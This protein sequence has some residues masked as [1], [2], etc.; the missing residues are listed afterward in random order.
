MGECVPQRD[1][2]KR[3]NLPWL[4]KNVVRHKRNAMF[5]IA[6]RS[7]NPTDFAK[8]KEIRNDV[9][10]MLRTAKQSYFDSLTSASSKQVWKM[11]KL[12]NKQEGSI[13][14]LS[15]DN[16]NAVKDEGKCNMLNSCFSK[17]WNYSEP[18]LIDPPERDY[19]EDDATYP[20]HLLCTTQEITHLLK[21][22][23]VSKATGPD[24]ISACMMKATSK[25]IALSLT[26]LFNL[27]ITKGHFPKLWKSARV[28][29]IPK[30]M[31]KHS[32][33]RYRPISLLS[34]LSKLLEK[35]F[36]FLITD[37]LAEHHSLS[38]AQWGF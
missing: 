10:T 36:H 3:R 18:P 23:D 13:P 9:T 25:S 30:S 15:K 37:H 22:L 32:P 24:G 2:K 12:V 6:K 16:V 21:G 20:D 11:V 19:V 7:E 35:H 5:Q 28:V 29:P 27:S 31:A 26:S 8:C 34:I 4:T 14:V 17:C 1:L 33:S 38:D